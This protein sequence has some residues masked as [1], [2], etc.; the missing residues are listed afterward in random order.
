MSNSELSRDYQLLFERFDLLLLIK[1]PTWS[2]ESR[3]LQEQTLK[4]TLSDPE[5]LKKIMTK[6]QVTDL[7]CIMRG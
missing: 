6:E 3:W 5:M 4:K 7:L 2:T 1:V